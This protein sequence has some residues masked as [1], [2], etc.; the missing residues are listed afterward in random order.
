MPCVGTSANAPPLMC[1]AGLD[2]ITIL[3]VPVGTLLAPGIGSRSATVVLVVHL[4]EGGF[5]GNGTPAL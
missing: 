3:C 4:L 2:A 1:I 5:P